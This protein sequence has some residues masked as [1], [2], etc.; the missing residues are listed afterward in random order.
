LIA[1]LDP[2]KAKPVIDDVSA[3][4]RAMKK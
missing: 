3:K 1:I 4:I 2:G